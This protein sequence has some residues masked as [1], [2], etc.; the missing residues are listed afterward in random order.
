MKPMR[1]WMG[2][3]LAAVSLAAG[4]GANKGGPMVI[5]PS[6]YAGPEIVMAASTRTHMADITTPTGGWTVTLDTVRDDFEV[7]RAFV[8]ITGPNPGDIV[9]QARVRHALDLGVS[10][11]QNAEVYARMSVVGTPPPE[12]YRFAGRGE[13]R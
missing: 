2:A 5:D 8:T 12:G 11:K 1:L 13:K 7:R 3:A 9:S 6:P 10:L 4:C